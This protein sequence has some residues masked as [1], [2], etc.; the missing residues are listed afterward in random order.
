MD[1]NLNGVLEWD[2]VYLLVCVNMDMVW[3]LKF[4]YMSVFDYW[5]NFINCELE[6]IVE[7]SVWDGIKEINIDI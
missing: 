2:D 3:F 4:F 7:L 6:I 5:N 1:F